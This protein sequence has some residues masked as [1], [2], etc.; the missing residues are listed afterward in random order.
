MIGVRARKRGKAAP[1]ASSGRLPAPAVSVDDEQRRHLI[2]CCA[3][4]RAQRFRES[5]PG[6]YREQDLHEAEAD[7]DSVLGAVWK[8]KEQ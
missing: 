3:F 5:G 7:I 6:Q 2:E 1:A 8:R 4:F